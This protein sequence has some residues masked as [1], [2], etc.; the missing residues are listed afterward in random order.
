MDI[1]ATVMKVSK[2]AIA[3]VCALSTWKKQKQKTKQNKTKQKQ[4][5]ET[6]H[7]KPKK[8]QKQQQQ[9][10][11]KTR[12]YWLHDNICESDNG[13]GTVILL[14]QAPNR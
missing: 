3:K 6:K 1:S 7:K 4:K 10:Q 11:D 8:K 12:N 9:T 13:I 14:Y 5:K 2:D